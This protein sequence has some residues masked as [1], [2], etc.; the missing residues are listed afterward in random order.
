MTAVS[1]NGGPKRL[2]N[3]SV[4][5]TMVSVMHLVLGLRI[6]NQDPC[7]FAVLSHTM[8]YHTI[9]HHTI[10]TYQNIPCCNTRYRNMPYHQIPLHTN[11]VFFGAPIQ[12]QQAQLLGSATSRPTMADDDDWSE[13]G[14]RLVWHGVGGGRG[15]KD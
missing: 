1:S 5:H 11:K 10:K 14:G 6:R 12:A 13:V 7:V 2:I 4:L 8:L 9:I 15:P 3:K